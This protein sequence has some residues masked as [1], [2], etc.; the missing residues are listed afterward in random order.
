M[1]SAVIG[2]SAAKSAA[3]TQATAATAGANQQAA[4]GQD[5]L[6]FQK[7]IDSRTYGDLAPY[8]AT[9]T[10]A[11]PAYQRLLGIGPDGQAGVQAALEA[12]PGYQFTRD[13]GIAS[14]ARALGSKGLTGAQAKGIGRFVTGLADNTYNTQLGNYNT[15][16]GTGLGAVGEGAG[17]G[18]QTGSSVGG[19]ASSIG[20]AITQGLTGAANATAGGTVG[21]ANAISGGVNGLSNAFLY[22]KLLGQTGQTGGQT[23]FYGNVIPKGIPY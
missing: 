19:T 4:L 14:E 10:A 6:N 16:V 7:G 5:A 17:I 23:D 11:L 2:S 20:Q 13:Q 12:T 21:S 15:A 8:R 3:K 9:G 18:A 1:G 22:S